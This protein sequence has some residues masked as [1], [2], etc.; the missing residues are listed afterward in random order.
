MRKVALVFVTM[1]VLMCTLT[2][3]GTSSE[4]VANLKKELDTMESR[5]ASLED[6]LECYDSLSSDIQDQSSTD[7][8]EITVTPTKTADIQ[9]D[10]KASEDKMNEEE[11]QELMNYLDEQVVSADVENWIE[12]ANC[13]YATE[14]HLMTIAENCVNLNYYKGYYSEAE[15]GQNDIVDALLTNPQLTDNV[16]KELSKSEY[17]SIWL[18]VIGSSKCSSTTLSDVATNCVNLNYYQG[19]Y[20]KAEAG[21]NMLADEILKSSAMNDEIVKKLLESDYPSIWLKAL[22][23]DKCSEETLI[24]ATKKCVAINCY[25]G[26]YSRAEEG[27]LL[28]AEAILQNPAITQN[29]LA[30]F[31][32]SDYPSIVSLGHQNIET[33]ST[34]KN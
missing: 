17:P 25:A 11:L 33:L 5:V 26:L 9:A 12:V 8:P 15:T 19:Y 22:S 29:V 31:V 1:F 3:C 21:Q 7:T 32:N 23:S 16:L 18:K 6:K 24:E 4:E 20:S 10:T 13:A 27:Q 34:A 2:A 30:E 28:L 14:D